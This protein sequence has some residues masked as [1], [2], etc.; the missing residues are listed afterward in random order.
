MFE[1]GLVEMKDIVLLYDLV[2]Y[3]F[4]SNPG[5]VEMSEFL[6]TYFVLWVVCFFMLYDTY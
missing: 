6:N 2:T 1:L 5:M 4:S 3:R